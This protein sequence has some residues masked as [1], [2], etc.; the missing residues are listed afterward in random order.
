M[1][2]ATSASFADA[3]RQHREAFGAPVQVGEA[4]L[5]GIV[6][7]VDLARELMEGGFAE[8]GDVDV[9]VMAD[10]LPTDVPPLGL[11]CAYG[12][13]RYRVASVRSREGAPVVHLR[14]RPARR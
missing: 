13:R 5:V 7:E 11:S 1:N 10:E 3:F 2:A 8:E 14:L 12:G 4:D 9:K 6:N